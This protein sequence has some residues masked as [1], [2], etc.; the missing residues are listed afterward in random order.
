[1]IDDTTGGSSAHPFSLVCGIDL[2]RLRNVLHSTTLAPGF[3]TSPGR[4]YPDS[5][6]QLPVGRR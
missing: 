1:V 2:N 5:S 4:P 3:R 6:V